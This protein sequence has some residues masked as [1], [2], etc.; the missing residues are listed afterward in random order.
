[1]RCRHGYGTEATPDVR[2]ADSMH[3]YVGMLHS[4]HR[5]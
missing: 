4:I 3:A 1:M 2:W 5:F